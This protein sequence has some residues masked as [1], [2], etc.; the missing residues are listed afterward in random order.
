MPYERVAFPTPPPPA[1]LLVQGTDSTAV[2]VA[3]LRLETQKWKEEMEEY[4]QRKAEH[5]AAE[6]R[7]AI[8]WDEAHARGEGG[9][10]ADKGKGRAAAGVTSSA[11]DSG[12]ED[13]DNVR[14][15][16]GPWRPVERSAEHTQTSA[17][18]SRR[19]R[20][21]GGT[22]I[23]REDPSLPWARSAEADAL[24]AQLTSLNEAMTHVHVYVNKLRQR[25]RDIDEQRLERIL[26]VLN[27]N[28]ERFQWLT[29]A[30]NDIEGALQVSSKK[31]CE[32]TE[33]GV[34]GFT[35]QLKEFRA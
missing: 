13:E 11:S 6:E 12:S 23:L 8:E 18:R 15:S 16:L 30:L 26:G 35:Q 1:P 22:V 14:R 10:A 9:A 34:R 25:S 27:A 17:P 33:N 28:T 32:A 2:Y 7:R 5:T 20:T 19:S 21:P 29:T 4:R 24:I 31:Y 3:R